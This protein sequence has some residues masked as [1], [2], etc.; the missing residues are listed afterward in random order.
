M[1]ENAEC[2]VVDDVEPDFPAQSSRDSKGPPLPEHV[3]ETHTPPSAFPPA[4]PRREI[5]VHE[6]QV[7]NRLHGKRP[8]DGI[9][10]IG[11][12][13]HPYLVARAG[14]RNGPMPADAGL[15]PLVRLA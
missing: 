5:V 6:L 4:R 1:T 9:S 2:N 3:I 8:L 13:E 7:R 12:R 15:R 10:V 11:A 14:E